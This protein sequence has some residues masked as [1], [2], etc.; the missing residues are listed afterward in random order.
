MKLKTATLL[1]FIGSLIPI[2]WGLSDLI[3]VAKHGNSRE[4]FGINTPTYFII[5]GY[6]IAD[7]TLSIFLFVLFKKQK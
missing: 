4:L 7:I 5:I 3:F 1:A 6:I 2:I